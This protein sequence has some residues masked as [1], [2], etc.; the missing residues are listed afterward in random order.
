MNKD[1][2]QLFY[3]NA[4]YLFQNLILFINKR[5]KNEINEYSETKGDIQSKYY[6]PLR[7]LFVLMII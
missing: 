5:I 2:P 7:I 3:N 4:N 6:D 1:C